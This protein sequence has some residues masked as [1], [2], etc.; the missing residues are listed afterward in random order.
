[1]LDAE[2]GILGGLILNPKSYWDIAE[3]DPGDF[4]KR[5]HQEYFEVI[6]KMMVA[7]DAVDLITVSDRIGGDSLANLG[8]YANTTHGTANIK[9]YSKLVREA[10]LRRHARAVLGSALGKLNENRDLNEV[11]GEVL[12]TLEKPGTNADK[13]FSQVLTDA[14]L[15]ADQAGKPNSE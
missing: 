5:T 10:S 3:L 2:I 9:H 1:M 14:L 15:A 6:R 7:G 11:I 13:A 4:A 12:T 8:G